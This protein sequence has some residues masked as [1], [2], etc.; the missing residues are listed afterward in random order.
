MFP[1]LIAGKTNRGT[2]KQSKKMPSFMAGC[3]WKRIASKLALIWEDDGQW[4]FQKYKF[5]CYGVWC[6]AYEMQLLRVRRYSYKVFKSI[7]Y[8]VLTSRA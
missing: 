1:T 2:V 6:Y 8:E 4:N 5:N 7:N 3:L